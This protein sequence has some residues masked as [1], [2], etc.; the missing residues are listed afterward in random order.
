[1]SVQAL[2]CKARHH[3]VGGSMLTSSF[4]SGETWRYEGIGENGSIHF[5]F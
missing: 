3:M 1:M 5:F 4:W 2:S